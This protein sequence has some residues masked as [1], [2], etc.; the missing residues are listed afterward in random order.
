MIT[1]ISDVLKRTNKY[2]YT[3]LSQGGLG[4]S[5][6]LLGGKGAGVVVG[7]SESKSTVHQ[8]SGGDCS[9]FVAVKNKDFV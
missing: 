9:A 1:S 6:E 4:M 5:I 7:R 3:Q 8:A 2:E